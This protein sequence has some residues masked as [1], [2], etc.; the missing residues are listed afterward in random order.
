[1]SV[2]FFYGKAKKKRQKGGGKL[3][4]RP[5]MLCSH[6]FMDSFIIKPLGPASQK[7]ALQWASFLDTVS[8]PIS[9]SG[10]SLHIWPPPAFLWVSPGNSA[11][12]LVSFATSNLRGLDCW[13]VEA[14]GW[15][16]Y[17]ESQEQNETTYIQFLIFSHLIETSDTLDH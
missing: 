11:S 7:I 16:V 9:A 8:G 2:L 1:M 10:S 6:L 5:R 12:P 4:G 13:D 14:G 17:S 3:L 15:W